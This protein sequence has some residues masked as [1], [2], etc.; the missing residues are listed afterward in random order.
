MKAGTTAGTGEG[1]ALSDVKIRTAKPKAHR[2]RLTDSHGLSIEVS[3]SSTPSE[4][5]KYWRYR[6]KL[7]GKENIFAAGEWCRVPTGETPEQAAERQQGGR[8][9]LAEARL[10][11]VTWR[12]QVKSGHHPRLVRAARQLLASQSAAS[13]FKAV[14]GEFVERRGGK[15]GESH[16][17][18]FTRFMEQDAYPDLG[19]LPIASLGPGHVLAVLHKVEGRGAHSVAR[20]GR[21]YL[22]QVFRYAVATHKATQDPTRALAG[23]LAKAETKHH[24]PLARD[25]IGP[26]L[27]AVE[28]KANA[29]R[30][31]EIAVR[32][33]LLTMT[34]TIELRTGW[35]SDVDDL[36]AEWRIPP[37]RM[38]M[39]RPHI[40][41]LSRQAVELL[42]EL[43]AITGN[44]PR[45]FPHTLDPEKAMGAST[46]GAVFIRA[47]YAG[48][49][50]PH[51]FRA[52]ASTMLREAGFEDR[53]IELQLAHIDRN[54]SRASYDHAERL[55]PRR[56]MMQAWAD[57]IDAALV[58]PRELR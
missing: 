54:K 45:L 50:S 15:W 16:R 11:R 38:K 31:T 8:L 22:G 44:S 32:L 35:W 18:H 43:R 28:T 2:Y 41:P 40:I 55:E 39:K 47:G 46:I 33:L 20:L 1:M 37:E 53:L 23:A 5:K 52:T 29:N 17:Q 7:G 3:P 56:A 58:S 13:T 27:K 42:K 14:A 9:T 19:A 10:A 12:A 21:G 48:Q 6:Y 51:G 49:F 57:M 34:R 30:Q 4:P 36:R 25:E 26:F 24:P